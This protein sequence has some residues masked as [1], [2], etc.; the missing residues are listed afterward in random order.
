MWPG[1]LGSRMQPLLGA[2]PCVS[3]RSRSSPDHSALGTRRKQHPD[4]T[5]VGRISRG[6]D[7][8]GYDFS[9]AGITGMSPSTGPDVGSVALYAS[10]II[11]QKSQIK[12]HQSSIRPIGH[13]TLRSGAVAC[14]IAAEAALPVGRVELVSPFAGNSDC[15]KINAINMQEVMIAQ[16]RS[17]QPGGVI[18]RK[19]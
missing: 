3:R 8:L 16:T 11:F 4:K 14:R 10:L 18:P 17:D 2:S 5:F 12:N 1:L 9:P 6:F 13:A 7:F 19:G 15:R